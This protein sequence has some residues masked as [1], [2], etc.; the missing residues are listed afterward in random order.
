MEVVTVLYNFYWH[1]RASSN[2]GSG[3]AGNS[4]TGFVLLQTA[5]LISVITLWLTCQHYKKIFKRI[6]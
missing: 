6:N 4:S 5:N 2:T 3:E 1:N